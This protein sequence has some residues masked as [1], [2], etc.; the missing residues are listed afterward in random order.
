[1]RHSTDQIRSNR[2]PFGEQTA[3]LRNAQRAT[4]P[5]GLRALFPF[6]DIYLGLQGPYLSLAVTS[7]TESA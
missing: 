3:P 4:L 6:Q 2:I 5:S 7:A 1:M